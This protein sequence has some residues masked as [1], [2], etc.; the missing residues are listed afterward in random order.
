MILV[1]STSVAWSGVFWPDESS[2]GTNAGAKAYMAK[3]FAKIDIVDGA[4][5]K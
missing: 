4:R 5:V 3:R 1:G 2:A